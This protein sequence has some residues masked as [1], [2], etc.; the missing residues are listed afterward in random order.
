MHEDF[1]SSTRRQNTRILL[2]AQRANR[3][4]HG[5]RRGIHACDRTASIDDH[6]AYTHGTIATSNPLII[7]RCDSNLAR[8]DYAMN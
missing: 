7:S 6:L 5:A 1:L 8:R 2:S 3:R 4:A